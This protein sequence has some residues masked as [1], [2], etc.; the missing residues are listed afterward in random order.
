MLARSAALAQARREFGSVA[1]MREDSRAAWQFRWLED[2]GADVRYCL[3]AFRRTPVFALTAVLSLALGIGANSAIFTALDAVLWRPLPVAAPEQLVHVSIT[4]GKLPEETDVP[5]AFASQLRKS[6]I[7]AGLA[8]TQND[9]LSFMYDGRA[10]RV[11]GEM[12]SPDYFAVLGVQPLLGQSFTPEVRAGH[13]AAEAVLSYNFWQRRFGGDPSVI[14]RTIHLNTYPFTITGVSPPGFFGANR[15]TDYE[16]R[17]PILPAGGE[18]AQ[19]EQISG[20]PDRWLNPVARLKPSDTREQAQAAADAQFQEWLR[21]TPLR[22]FQK[23]HLEHVRLL[24]GGRGYDEYVHSFQTPLY[25]LLVL[26]GIV[27]L[28]ACANVA[29]VL[30]ARAAARTREIAVRASVGAGRL[31]LVRQMLAESIVLAVVGGAL[32]L[33]IA[34]WAAVALFRFLPQGHI[35]LAIDLHP[36]RRALLFTFAISLLTGLVFGLVPAMQATR[37]DLAA[38]LKSN[39]D[40]AAGDRHGAGFRKTS[41]GDAGGLFADAV[42]RG[43]AFRAHSLQPPSDREFAANPE[44][45]LL[46]TMKPQPEMYTTSAN[47]RLPGTWLPAF[48]RCPACDRPRLPRTVRWAAGWTT[49]THRTARPHSATR[50]RGHDHSRLFS[51][52]PAFLDWRGVT[53]GPEI[54]RNRRWWLSSIRRWRGRLLVIGIRSAEVLRVPRGKSDGAYEVVGV[55]ADTHYYDIHRRRAFRVVLDGAVGSSTCRRC[56]C[57]RRH[58]TR[59]RWWLRSA[60][61]STRSTRDS[62]C[63]TSGR[64]RTGS[65]TRSRASGW[66]RV[67]R[68]RSDFSRRRSRRWGCTASSRIRF[69]GGSARSEFAW[70]WAR[71]GGRCC[72]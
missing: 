4:R 18:L 7:F 13:W 19:V 67:S 62:R 42:D 2:L 46:F 57:A 3:R 23:A 53:S 9:G 20:R 49:R 56:T 43:R 29:N 65:R 68:A 45:V 71:A 61:S 35:N 44:R 16:M 69:R 39:S 5:A 27:L 48:P 72:G 59:R 26:A 32:G 60:A 33:A 50:R 1:L 22:R 12:V 17:I 54:R 47:A 11:I 64:C 15:G 21:T 8:V 14:G 36:D 38:A 51:R 52:R 40:G 63:S 25:V 34:N 41:G 24:P 28:I 6:G 70:L 55:V 30:L 58:R 37:G 66:W 31:R 10:E